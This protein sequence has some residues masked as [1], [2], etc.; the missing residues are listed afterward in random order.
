MRICRRSVV[1]ALD[2]IKRTVKVWSDAK[3]PT[4]GAALSYYTLFSI[5]PLLVI[6]LAVAGM[7]FGDRA[8]SGELEGDIRD[9]VGPKVAESIADMLRNANRPQTGSLAIVI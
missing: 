9:T 1:K 8:A 2:L 4:F 6:A 7:T 5:A 3:A